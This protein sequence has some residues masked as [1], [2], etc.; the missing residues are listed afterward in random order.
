[1]PRPRIHVQ[2]LR[3]EPVSIF[4]NGDSVDPTLRAALAL[5]A[6][7]AKTSYTKLKKIRSA[8][9]P[10]AMLRNQF[11]FLGSPRAGRWSGQDVQ[12][13]NMAKAIK[14]LESQ[15]ALDKVRAAIYNLDYAAV[16]AVYPG[17]ITAVTSCIRSDFVAPPGMR[18]NVAD[19]NAIE[20]RASAWFCECESLMDVFRRGDCPYIDLG[21][22]I[23]EKPASVL[24]EAYRRIK[25]GTPTPADLALNVKK[26]RTDGKPGMLGC[27]YRLSGGEWTVNR[28]KDTVKGGLWGY[29]ENM[30]IKI[31]RDTCHK[32]VAIFREKY[33]EIRYMWYKLEDAVAKVLKHGG[34]VQLGPNG[35]VT[36]GRITRRGKY[37]ILVHPTSFGPATALHRRCASRRRRA[38]VAAKTASRR[39]VRTANPRRT[40]KKS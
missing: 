31:D 20:T 28:Y 3:K 23:Y 40:P 34:T 13:H 25:H 39:S 7:S 12:L 36:I 11:L 2:V 8:I 4:L 16:K 30:G 15:E 24:Q 21:A 1:M 9:A 26:I 33:K 35:C 17:V 29:A 27:V 22:S 37:P 38:R 5:R 10:D 18:L 19:L 14:E 32:I 6:E